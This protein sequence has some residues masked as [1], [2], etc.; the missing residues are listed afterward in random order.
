MI[1]GYLI[2]AVVA[3]TLALLSMYRWRKT[4]IEKTICRSSDLAAARPSRLKFGS[5]LTAT[6]KRS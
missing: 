1:D 6:Q 3:A 2:A 4:K 5:H